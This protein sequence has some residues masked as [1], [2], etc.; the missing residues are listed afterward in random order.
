MPSRRLTE[1]QTKSIRAELLAK[2]ADKVAIAAKWGVS[3]STINRVINGINP[4]D[5]QTEQTKPLIL[6]TNWPAYQKGE[7]RF[8][9][10]L[11]YVGEKL[12]Q[13]LRG[14][15]AQIY[16]ANRHGVPHELFTPFY[17]ATNAFIALYCMLDDWGKDFRGLVE[18]LMMMDTHQFEGWIGLVTSTGSV[19]GHYP[20]E[21]RPSEDS[22]Y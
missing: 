20:Q 1:E 10:P 11:E 18:Q 21:K 8:G 14:I 3:M 15:H 19:T 22:Q 13:S 7:T 2:G 5:F 16:M 6:Q 17:H 9:P 4:Y 12:E